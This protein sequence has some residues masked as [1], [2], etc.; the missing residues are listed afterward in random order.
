MCN[1][2]RFQSPDILVCVFLFLSSS[3]LNTEMKIYIKH[4]RVSGSQRHVCPC[5]SWILSCL[6]SSPCLSLT[7]CLFIVNFNN[8][9]LLFSLTQNSIFRLLWSETEKFVKKKEFCTHIIFCCL[10]ITTWMSAKCDR[11]WMKFRAQLDSSTKQ[12]HQNKD[13]YHFDFTLRWLKADDTTTMKNFCWIFCFLLWSFHVVVIWFIKIEV[14][15]ERHRELNKE[16]EEEAIN[17]LC[18]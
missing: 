4:R 11:I 8:K 14:E 2:K 10:H 3:L 17:F 7:F 16:E 9:N 13:D 12:Q 15:K 18:H 1:W 5:L 6:I